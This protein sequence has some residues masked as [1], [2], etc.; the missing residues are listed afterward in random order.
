LFPSF[1][2][3]HPTGDS[4]SLEA[5]FLCGLRFHRLAIWLSNGVAVI[6]QLLLTALVVM[7][8]FAA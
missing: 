5:W 3:Q 8:A 2:L 4:H 6:L 1:D 7:R